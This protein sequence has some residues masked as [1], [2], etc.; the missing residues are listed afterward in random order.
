MET[1]RDG[2]AVSGNTP[3]GGANAS[4]KKELLVKGSFPELYE[5]PDY[6]QKTQLAD[7][8]DDLESDAAYLLWVRDTLPNAI[9]AWVGKQYV[10]A[11]GAGKT[12]DQVVDQ[13][14]GEFR[15]AKGL[16]SADGVAD[17]EVK[18]IREK[19]RDESDEFMDELDRV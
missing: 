10:A 3:A 2:G 5:V 13:L 11:T 14:V 19:E 17:D 12:Y 1:P 6:G 16:T 9:Y 8:V 18:V 4:A 7:G 15:V